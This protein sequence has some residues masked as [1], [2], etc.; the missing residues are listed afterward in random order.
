MI[1]GGKSNWEEK[2]LKIYFLL[3]GRVEKVM[4][5]SN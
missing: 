1:P 3:E 5:E 2:Y 4:L